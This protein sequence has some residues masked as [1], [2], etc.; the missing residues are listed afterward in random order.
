MSLPPPPLP[1]R[2]PQMMNYASPAPASY[3]GW[4]AVREGNSILTR[5]GAMLPPFCIKCG[6]P[7]GVKPRS[8]KMYWHEPW[9]YLLIL[10]GL[11]VYIIAALVM[12]QSA[13]VHVHLCERHRNSRAGWITASVGG[14]VLSI[15]AFIAGI[16]LRAPIVSLVGVPFFIISLIILAIVNQVARP[17]RIESP[18]V[19][20]KCSSEEFLAKLST[21]QPLNPGY[22]PPNYR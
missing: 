19:W 22:F 3:G 16:N 8:C 7:D 15:V 2:M 5:D 14:I 6:S 20:I 13:T 18:M 17:Q 10:A 11:L 4:W 9:V 12:R 21:P 1:P